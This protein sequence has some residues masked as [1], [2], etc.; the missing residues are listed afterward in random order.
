MYFYTYIFE[1]K[2]HW[3]KFLIGFGHCFP[4]EKKAISYLVLAREG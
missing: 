1:F 3:V 4:Y 2:P